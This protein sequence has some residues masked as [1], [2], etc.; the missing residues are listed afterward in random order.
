MLFLQLLVAFIVTN[1][2]LNRLFA[3]ARQ[4][5]LRREQELVRTLEARL[6]FGELE[7][8]KKL[9]WVL[10]ALAATEALPVDLAGTGAFLAM[11]FLTFEAETITRLLAPV[12][13]ALSFAGL[14][15]E[16]AGL[17]ITI[18]ALLVAG[19]FV[20]LAG[21]VL[22]ALTLRKRLRA[23]LAE[24]RTNPR[25][26]AHLTLLTT[27]DPVLVKQATRFLPAPAHDSGA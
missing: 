22:V 1:L 23:T 6:P 21:E 2:L 18:S 14:G 24:L 26:P 27:L 19:F 7:Q 17:I 25:F 10:R 4:R 8:A 16:Q 9:R 12:L 11:V 15:P 20:G 3:P 5:A 13:L